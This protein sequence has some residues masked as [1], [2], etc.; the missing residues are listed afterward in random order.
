M[1][2]M[3]KLVS[4]TLL[5]LC[6]FVYAQAQEALHVQKV[7]GTV[8]SSSLVSIQRIIFEEDVMVITASEGEY[9]LPL[10]NVE[11]ITFS[12]SSSAIENVITNSI[13][14]SKSGNELI[15]ESDNAMEQL[16]LVDASGKV[17]VSDRLASVNT[18]SITLPNSGVFV[19]FLKTS[20]GYI[21]KK[22]I[23][24]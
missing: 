7:D 15:I 2:N 11:K 21:A 10:D 1:E 17:I 9:R 16:Y 12:D 13:Q 19:L 22:V 4:V 23:Y 6:P 24:N 5:F 18:T 3:K 8:L 20:K 14:I